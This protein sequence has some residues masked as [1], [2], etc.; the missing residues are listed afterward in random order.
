MTAFPRLKKMKLVDGSSVTLP[1][2]V[3]SFSS[4]GFPW[5]K[6]G[7][8]TLSE[9]NEPFHLM[10][11]SL[12][13]S[14]LVSAH[15][16]HHGLI[17]CG[18]SHLSNAETV[19][20]D[21]GGYEKKPFF[22]AT[23]PALY[24]Y[25][26]LDYEVEDYRSVLEG[27][28]GSLPLVVTNPDWHKEGSEAPDQIA[29][30]QEFLADFGSF[31]KSMILKPTGKAKY[32]SVESVATCI[33]DLAAFQ[34][35]GVTEKELGRTLKERLKT[36]AELRRDLNRADLSHM[37]IHVWGGLDPVITPLYF[38]AG[39]D[40]FDGLS[41]LRY[42]FHA[43]AATYR[44]AWQILDGGNLRS[45]DQ[46]RREVLIK[47]LSELRRLTAALKH[48]RDSDGPDFGMFDWHR[49][50]LERAYDEMRNEIPGIGAWS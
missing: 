39:A 32:F 35:V 7:S 25:P 38:F 22:E 6:E 1:R 48:F 44:D 42:V 23:E 50:E 14:F 30:A 17:T 16:L 46:S 5:Y 47:N 10:N 26:K 18:K 9:V 31:T 45:F 15:D 21:S 37:P 27:L 8:K 41:W 3:P 36:V 12:E 29:F 2:L 20:L 28:D 40:I 43:G 13:E 33:R 24:P 11:G 4:K 49:S 19:F 34:L